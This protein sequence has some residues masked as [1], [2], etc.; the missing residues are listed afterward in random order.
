M[1]KNLFLAAVALVALASC[2]SDEFT[3]ENITPSSS[4]TPGA[5]QF[6]S[7]TPRITRA[8]GADAAS[9][10]YHRFKVYGVKKTGSNYSNV[11]ATNQYSGSTDYNAAPYWVWY[12][13]TTAGTTASDTKDWDYVGTNGTNHGTYYPDDHHITLSTDQTIKYW[14]YSADQYEFVAYSATVGTPTITKYQKDG[15][16][17]QATAEQLAGLYVADKLTI[18]AKNNTPTKPASGFN[19][20]GNIVQLTFRAA[21]AKVRLG[22]YETIPGYVVQNVNFRPNNT[23]TPEFDATTAKAKLSGSFNGTSSSANGTYNVTYNATTGVAEF[24]NTG[25]ASNNFDFGSFASATPTNAPTPLGE[26]STTPMWATGSSKYQSVLP[27]TDNVGNMILYVDYDLY[28]S[29]SGETIH[30]YGAKAVVPSIYMAW[31]PNYAYTYLFKIS[32]NTNGATSQSSGTPEGLYPITFDAVTIAATDGQEVGTITTV[33]TPAITTYQNG[34]VSSA[35]ITYATATTTEPIYITVNTDGTLASL[36]GNIKLYKLAAADANATEADLV[37]VPSK[38]SGKEVAS[39]STDA[40]SVLTTAETSQNITF[41]ASTSAKFIPSAGQ[42]YAVEYSKPTYVAATGTY[43]SGTTYY[44]DN[45]GATTVDTTGFEE[46][47]T[48]VS[49]YF[50]NNPTKHYKVIKVAAAS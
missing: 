17:V 34:S 20:I 35:G 31:H 21:A 4:N 49:S 36:T 12:V 9:A 41:A 19:Q 30:V 26:T 16:T 43:V 33:S 39:G 28:N 38:L 10:L 13:A 50:V 14:D 46:G 37:L 48:D 27:N 3:G 40:L 11:F 6:A 8:S 32:D 15:F 23:T 44:T 5:I 18:T 42:T 22:I 29:V 2:T 24:D 47:V 45:T 1:K 7:N 25:S